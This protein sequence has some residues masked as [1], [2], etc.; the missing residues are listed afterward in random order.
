MSYWE[1]CERRTL[2]FVSFLAN[3][4]T[5]TRVVIVGGGFGGLS[6]A[7][8]LLKSEC[9]EDVVITLIDSSPMSTYTPWLDNVATQKRGGIA[10]TDIVLSAVPG[11]R[12]RLGTMDSLNVAEKQVVLLDGSTVPY[13]ICVLAVGSVANDFGI[14]GVEQFSLPMKRTSD[15]ER[16]Q[17]K[18]HELIALPSKTPRRVVIVGA[19]PNGVELAA[20]SAAIGGEALEVILVDSHPNLLSFFS[21]FLQRRTMNR[22]A[23]LGVVLRLGSMLARVTKDSVVFRSMVNGVPVEEEQVVPCDLCIV[24]LGV[25]TPD[26]VLR[27]PFVKNVQGRVLVDSSFRV[28]DRDDIFVLGDCAA[29]DHDALGDPKTAQA[30]VRQSKTVAQN[31]CAMIVQKPMSQYVP[32]KHWDTLV[33]L[34]GVR[35]VG[36]VFGIP[37]WG[38]VGGVFRKVADAHYFFLVL[39]WKEALKKVFLF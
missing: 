31:I 4:M 23:S 30:A 22:L 26:V 8:R 21:L 6:V 27:F 13:D 14:S 34:D 29:M 24:A 9:A 16:I 7:A 38:Y 35:A 39:P 33:T 25:K 37:V 28:L 10:P 5:Q 15:A 2:L 36:T 3:F 17:K 12:F 18:L 1:I 20:E 11:V 19:G 32:K